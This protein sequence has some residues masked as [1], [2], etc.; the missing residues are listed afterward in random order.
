MAT[1][2]QFEMPFMEVTPMKRSLFRSVSVL[3]VILILALSTLAAPA[4]AG[5]LSGAGAQ[6]EHRLA[7]EPNGTCAY[8]ADTSTGE[9][10]YF[11]GIQVG[12]SGSVIDGVESGIRVIGPIVGALPSQFSNNCIQL[13]PS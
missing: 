3:T 10:H 9:L 1:R 5:N 7:N 11:I 2:T 4:F 6:L 13:T 8:V 12:G